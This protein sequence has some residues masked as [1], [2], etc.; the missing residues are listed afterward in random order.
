[1]LYVIESWP[2]YEASEEINSSV[3]WFKHAFSI[4]VMNRIHTSTK[5][6]IK[7]QFGSAGW[8]DYWLVWKY[9]YNKALISVF[10]LHMVRTAAYTEKNTV[11]FR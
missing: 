4:N 3:T 1:M 5:Q 11:K 8:F 2:L 6:M 9:Y 10:F 7:S